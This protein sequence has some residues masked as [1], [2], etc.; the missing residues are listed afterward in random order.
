MPENRLYEMEINTNEAAHQR[1]NMKPFIHSVHSQYSTANAVT[2]CP[3][4]KGK[5]VICDVIEDF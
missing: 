4:I 5:V 3:N 2:M 1:I